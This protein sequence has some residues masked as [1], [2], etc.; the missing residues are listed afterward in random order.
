[1]RVFLGFAISLLSNI[2]LANDTMRISNVKCEDGWVSLGKS[3]LEVISYCGQPKYIDIISGANDIKN[4]DLL[5]TIKRKDY[6]VSIR[7]GKVARI[8]MVK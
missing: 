8:G 4:E 1:M 2:V 3:K 7:A 6:I 5:Y